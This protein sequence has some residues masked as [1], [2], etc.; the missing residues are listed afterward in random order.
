MLLLIFELVVD[1]EG[2][3]A[4]GR[5]ASVVVD[6]ACKLFLALPGKDD[7]KLVVLDGSLLEEEVGEF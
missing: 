6:H 2:L 1:F 3:L 5:V 4:G 7:E